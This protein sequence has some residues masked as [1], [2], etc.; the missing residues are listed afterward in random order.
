VRQ[1]IRF[2]HLLNPQLQRD[3]SV[4]WVDVLPKNQASGRVVGNTRSFICSEKQRKLR[5]ENLL[6]LLRGEKKKT[7]KLKDKVTEL[8]KEG[9]AFQQKFAKTF[10]GCLSTLSTGGKG[11]FFYWTK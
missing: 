4:D 1:A 2:V 7:I 9:I 10:R 8:E 6:Q 11:T 5:H 3:D